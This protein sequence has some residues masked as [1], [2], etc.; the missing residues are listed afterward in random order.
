MAIRIRHIFVLLLLTF[1]SH[2]CFAQYYLYSDT[3]ANIEASFLQ[4]S[5]Q[6]SAKQSFFNTLTLKNKANR[7]ET[8]TL[9][10][11]VPDG[12]SVVGANKMEITLQPLDSIVIPIRIA[13]ASKVRGDIGYSVIASLT[14]NKGNSIRNVYCFVK[15]PRE[16][17]LVV[18]YSSRI[19]FL[20]PVLKSSEFSVLVQNKGN[21]E[22]LVNFL[23][24]GIRL[25]CIGDQKDALFS[26]DV[27]IPPF[28]DSLFTF[29]VSLKQEEQFGK[30]TFSLQAKVST[31]DTSYQ[32]TLWF[33]IIDSS[34]KNEISSTDMPLRF[35]LYAQGL[36]D[37]NLK[38]NYSL[39]LEGKTLF[40]GNS[41]LYYLYRNFNSKNNED[42]FV[43]NRMHLGGTFGHWTLEA[44]DSYRSLESS[45]YGRGGYA[46][47]NSHKVK[48]EL[49]ATKN[50][51]SSVY[52]FGS[53]FTYH[54][55]PDLFIQS[56]MAYNSS[57]KENYNSKLGFIG[58]G[59]TINKQHSFLILSSFN[60]LQ[61]EFDNKKVHNE[62][63]VQFNYS[64][65][66]GPFTSYIISR[67]GSNHLNSPYAG[68]FEL[69]SNIIWR[70]NNSNQLVALY[71][72]NNI[73]QLAFQNTSIL[74]LG[75]LITREG[76]LQ[77]RHFASNNVEVFGGPIV[78]N[79][80]AIGLNVFPENTHFQ[81][82]NTK[83]SLGARL[84]NTANSVIITP[85]FEFAIAKILE[86]PFLEISP[87]NN[88]KS[89]FFHHLSLSMRTRSLMF[90][91]FYTSG[92]RSSF[93]QINY[94]RTGRQTRKIQFLPTFDKFVYKDIVKV[95]LGLSYS[96]DMILK[97]TYSTLNGL[98]NVYLPK[99]WELQFLGVYSL[100]KR[101]NV[102]ELIETYQSLYLEVGIKKDFNINQP[103]VKYYDIE[104]GFFKDY[105]GNF[106]QEENEPGIK[107]VLVYF[108]K[109]SSD[110]KGVIP[111]D[112]S[113]GE[114]LSDN[115]GRVRLDKVPEGIYKINYNP[116][117]KEAGSFTKASESLELS[118]NRS[119]KFYFPFVEKNKVFGKVILSRSRLSGLG[120][121]DV[122]NIRIT[123]TD[124]KGRT[125]TT[126]TDKNG[127]FVVFAPVTDQYI[128]NINNIFYENFD[129]RQNN[130]KVQFNGYKQF[131]VNF[132][133]DE[134]IRRVNFSPSTQDAQLANIMQV[135]RTNLRGSVKDASSLTPIRAR[136]NLVNTK[137]NTVITSMY[138]SSQTG[139]YSISFMA[140]DYYLL[141]ILADGYWYHSENLNLNQ[142]TT[143]LNVTKDVLLKPIA[144]GSK[145]ELNIRF[146]INK[147]DLASESVAELNRL[148]RLLKDNGNIKIEV[149]GH[150]DDLEA[151]SN[152]QIS[153]E[154]AKIVARFLIENGFSNIQIRGFG[155]TIPI[156]SNDTEQGRALNR[157]VEI[158]V[159]SK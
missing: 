64:S 25:L 96:N 12:W 130:F 107:N 88:S 94:L 82:I 84:K 91:A 120:K 26:S 145:I 98:L 18:K 43:N 68:K 147:T 47:Y 127:E 92:P 16:T 54:F 158:E 78:E 136:V 110:V 156:S 59:F 116:I 111:G 149:Q 74:N 42:F 134:K 117:G 22:E 41:E 154:R 67:F 38:P 6:S 57:Q 34:T 63:G 75:E 95:N 119:G 69:L 146:D 150:S 76:K 115:L 33:R 73:K 7:S 129:L 100:Q 15:I 4:H 36:A 45:M 122:S 140:D 53:S 141:E 151:L 144:I 28:S 86:N 14:D 23:F 24:D 20:D 58:T 143:F 99:N 159:V 108:E 61:R 66:V 62:Y 125:Y 133:F 80:V 13:V 126:L 32:N 49:M 106:I 153:E 39:L 105:N 40:K 77:L 60:Q 30:K 128:V 5:I 52:N 35:E 109:V 114:L 70:I 46:A 37:I 56:G 148:I 137:N 48:A 135:R 50:L 93:D 101:V 71:N 97:S 90:M 81:S 3:P 1:S 123:A 21:R 155:N 55:L 79:N 104:F 131:E 124:S 139:D 27:S 8:F 31:I 138:S 121:L 118:I 17:M 112:F 89:F 132:V 103:R 2:L 10:I 9:N 142:V 102:Q 11:T 65:T 83:A 85:S 157:R 44:G 113:T 87:D 72:Q 51:Q 19:F 29:R 152:P